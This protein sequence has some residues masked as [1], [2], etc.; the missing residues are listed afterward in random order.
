MNKRVLI[1]DNTHPILKEKLERHN[2]VC[3]DFTGSTLLELEEVIGNYNG[4]IIRSRFTFDKDLLDKSTNLEF[5]GRVGAGME[6]IDIEYAE[7]KNI[8]CYNSPEGNRD[9]VGEHA[10]GML[11]LLMNKLTEANSQVAKGLWNREQNRGLE[12]K[13]RTVGIIGYGNMGGSFARKISGFGANVIA[14][15][16]YKKDY[17]DK[18]ATEV[19]LETLLAESDIISLHVPLTDETKFMVNNDFFS[20]LSKPIFLINTARGPVVKTKDLV[21]AL[22]LGKVLGAGLDVIEYEETSFEKVN[23]MDRA[24]FRNLAKLNNVTLSPHIG[25]WTVESKIKLAEVLADKIINNHKE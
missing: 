3:D 7:S 1:I 12:I 6:S 8:K 19:S 15:D 9:A 10:L 22:K 25:G 24:D 21:E 20:K 13:G 17:S 11:L 14:Y 4:A 18:Y 23:L 16:K 2:F 5:I